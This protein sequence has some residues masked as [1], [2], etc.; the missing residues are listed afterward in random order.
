MTISM[1]PYDKNDFYRVVEYAKNKNNEDYKNGKT[2][3]SVYKCNKAIIDNVK[4]VLDGRPYVLS[5]KRG[6]SF[7]F[8]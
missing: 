7:D 8:D 2:T 4:E 3:E 6:D 1:S 5:D